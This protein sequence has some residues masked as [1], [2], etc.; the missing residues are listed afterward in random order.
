MKSKTSIKVEEDCI[1]FL[2]KF[3]RNRIKLDIDE[4]GLSYWELINLIVKYFKSDGDRYLELVNME[5]KN[6]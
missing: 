3:K 6:A 4:E 2:K 1:Q 5:Y